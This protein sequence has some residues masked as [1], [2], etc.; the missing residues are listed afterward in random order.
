[1][2]EVSV[3]RIVQRP[4]DV[5]FDFVARRHFENHPRWDPDPLEMS[6]TSPGP[7]GVGT[8]ARVVRR[9]GRGRVEGTATVVAYEPDRRAAWDVR[10]GP[11]RLDQRAEFM[12]EDGGASTRLQ[13]SIDASAHGPVR[14]LVPLLRGRFRKT[15]TRSLRTVAHHLAFAGTLSL[16]AETLQMIVHDVVDS[17]ARHGFRRL[18]LLPTHGGNERPLQQAAAAAERDS[19]TIVVPSLRAAVGALVAVARA[20]GVSAGEAGGHAGEL[21]TSLMLALAPRL[22]RNAAMT[23][24]G[25]TGPL[26]D[27][28]AAVFFEKG[29]EALAANGVLGDPRRASTDAGH[30]YITAFVEAIE[31]QLGDA[32]DRPRVA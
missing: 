15:M 25:Y 14:M 12:P 13:L 27:A 32:A 17:L 21:E 4:P 31:R 20:R 28:A 23:E 6:Q 7:V 9:Q 10:F 18:V 30:A 1:V 19:V 22:V 5:V 26:D 2:T 29:V 3:E 24:P 16:R 11:F 8:T